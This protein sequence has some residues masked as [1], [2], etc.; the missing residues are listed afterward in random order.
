MT[1][2]VCTCCILHDDSYY[3]R[4]SI[5]RIGSTAPV[6]CFVSTVAWHACS[7]RWKDAVQLLRELGA[8]V[9][10]GEWHS[11]IEHRCATQEWLLEQGFTHAF[12]P[13]GDEIIEPRL[14][15]LLVHVAENELA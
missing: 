8:N 12:I 10:M 9:V 6:H 3:L 1:T 14:L 5:G 2:R 4:E 11:E 15:E 7:G 13:D